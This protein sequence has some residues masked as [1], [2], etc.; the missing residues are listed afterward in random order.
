M[1]GYGR[2][3]FKTAYWTAQKG[4]GTNSTTGWLPPAAAKIIGAILVLLRG[5]WT[6]VPMIWSR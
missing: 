1:Y 5:I 4:I 3:E 6:V 2:K